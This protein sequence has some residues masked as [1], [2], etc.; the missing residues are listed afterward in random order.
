MKFIA[1]Y[2]ASNRIVIVVDGE[3][4]HYPQGPLISVGKF[5]GSEV[6]DK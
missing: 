1:V 2:T 6:V 3:L 5:A 4:S